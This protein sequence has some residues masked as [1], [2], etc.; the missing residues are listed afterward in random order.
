MKLDK[1][2]EVAK[3]VK[4]KHDAE[5]GYPCNCHYCWMVAEIRRKQ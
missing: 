1:L 4:R 3:E 2:F 5:S